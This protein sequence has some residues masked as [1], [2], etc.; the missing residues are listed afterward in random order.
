M[1]VLKTQN[2]LKKNVSCLRT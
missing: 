1:P 2:V